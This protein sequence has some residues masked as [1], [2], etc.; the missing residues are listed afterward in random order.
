M[1]NSLEEWLIPVIITVI[2][3]VFQLRFFMP[4]LSL[5]GRLK[6]IFPEKP[7]DSLAIGTGEDGITE[8]IE[9]IPDYDLS[10]EFKE[11]CLKPINQ[12]LE[13]NKVVAEYGV[14]KEM[15]VRLSNSMEEQISA[16]SPLPV[17]V[18]L[19]GTLAGILVGVL[20]LTDLSTQNLQ[21]LISGIGVAM[22]TTLIGLFLSIW[23]SSNFKNATTQNERKLNAF[24]S[25]VQ[26]QLLPKMGDNDMGKIFNIFQRNLAAFNND[27]AQNILKFEGVLSSLASGYVQQTEVIKEIKGLNISAMADA[28]V[29]VLRELQASGEQLGALQK[30]LNSSARYL[31]N[32][33]KLNG[34]LEQYYK[35]L[36][37][38]A[39]EYFEEEYQQMKNRATDIGQAVGNVDTQL[40]L[41]FEGLK[42]KTLKEFEAIKTL[43]A[44]QQSEFLVAVDEE[45]KLLRTKLNETSALL[46]EL[47]QLTGVKKEM[48]ALTDYGK[49]ITELLGGL[50]ESNKSLRQAIGV[51]KQ[52]V[53]QNHDEIEPGSDKRQKSMIWRR[54]AIASVKVG[55]AAAVLYLLIRLVG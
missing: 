18:G 45:G 10:E 43:A 29:R 40:K 7:F 23:A 17:N 24:L 49:R 11:E 48:S 27:F 16:L 39:E 28:N 14:I 51:S 21:S 50:L 42:E 34:N 33:E 25:W 12:Y 26:S 54:R 52:A 55:Y 44:N 2:C 30:F 47:H 9:A 1:S 6:K 3:G 46:E 15:S 5:I 8:I 13:K 38:K 53:S 31:E 32:V 35:S 41:A 37:E 22:I 20:G 19:V 36:I 4:T